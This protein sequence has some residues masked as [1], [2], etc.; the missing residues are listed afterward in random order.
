MVEVA[1]AASAGVGDLGWAEMKAVAVPPVAAKWGA[2]GTQGAVGHSAVV[3]PVEDMGKGGMMC[4]ARP[5]ALRFLASDGRQQE[6][7]HCRILH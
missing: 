5:Q 6:P 3:E 2:W 1:E 7:S 4:L